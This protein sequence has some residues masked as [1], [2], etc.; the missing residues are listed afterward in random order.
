MKEGAR[1]ELARLTAARRGVYPSE[2]ERAR[3]RK[4]NLAD[5]F[6]LHGGDRTGHTRTV[7][8]YLY[9]FAALVLVKGASEREG[10]I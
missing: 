3:E 10:E 6:A 8:L 4:V 7:Y 1:E 5:Y 2:R 9:S